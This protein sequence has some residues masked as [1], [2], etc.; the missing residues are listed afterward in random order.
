MKRMFER[1]KNFTCIIMWSLCYEAENGPALLRGYSWLKRRDSS[2]PVQHENVHADQLLSF[3]DVDCIDETDIYCP[4]YPTPSQL[5]AYGKSHLLIL[6][7][8]VEVQ[9]VQGKG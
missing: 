4:M 2:R 1:D 5:E 6:G 8:R 9:I 7:W 3:H